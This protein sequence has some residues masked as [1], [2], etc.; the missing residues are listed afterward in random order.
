M[1]DRDQDKGL[2]QLGVTFPRQ[3]FLRD[4]QKSRPPQPWRFPAPGE[5]AR[6]P[7]SLKLREVT[8]NSKGNPGCALHVQ[9]P[10]PADRTPCVWE[11]PDSR[12]FG[13]P[14]HS[15]LFAEPAPDLQEVGHADLRPG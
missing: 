1:V 5:R 2:E 10:D 9:N 6:N 8:Q 11:E 3:L 7:K 4:K 15:R 14:L 13:K 12:E